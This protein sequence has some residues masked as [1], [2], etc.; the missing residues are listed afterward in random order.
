MRGFEA[1]ETRVALT[2]ARYPSFPRGPA[3]V[4]RLIKSL[5]KRIQDEA[6]QVLRP[7]GINHSEYTVLMML[8]GSKDYHLTPSEL[9]D[10]AME[11]STN[12]TRLTDCLCARG[13]IARCVD[14][15]DRR[16]VRVTLTGN[17]RKMIHEF[18]PAI[19]KMLARQT[20]AVSPGDL[21]RLESLLEHFLDSVEHD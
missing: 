12:I 13:L 14:D 15:R 11:K 2:C 10:A 18:L 21:S 7:W 9:A 3:M 4:V 19:E 6:N 20:R 17:G 8:F 1:T 5:Y 16:R